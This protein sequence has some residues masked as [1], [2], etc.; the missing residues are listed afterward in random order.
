LVLIVNSVQYAH[1]AHPLDGDI[2]TIFADLQ[3]THLLVNNSRVSIIVLAELIRL[4][5]S[6][7]SLTVESSAKIIP[8]F[9]SDEDEQHFRLISSNNEITKLNLVQTTELTQIAFLI[10]LCPRMQ[11]LQMDCPNTT[12]LQL[13]VRF[14]LRQYAKH[15]VSLSIWVPETSNEMVDGLKRMIHREK[16]LDDYT[17]EHVHNR[18]HLQWK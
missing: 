12:D 1:I 4:F 2:I 7:N 17:I 18:I 6:L 5:H 13:L 9:L 8:R 10:E 11:Y 15:L 3:F 14:I 16:L